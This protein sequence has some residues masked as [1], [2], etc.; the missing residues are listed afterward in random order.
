MKVRR[1]TLAA[2]LLA[3]AAGGGCLGAGARRAA[4]AG[5]AIDPKS[6]GAP[7]LV[8]LLS[9][10]SCV[11]LLN[12]RDLWIA[13]AREAPGGLRVEAFVEPVGSSAELAAFIDYLKLPF[14][15]SVLPTSAVP[16]Q[17]R[18]Q[19]RAKVLLDAEGNV[20]KAFPVALTP[21]ERRRLPAD[22]R[23]AV[24]TIASGSAGASR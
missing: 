6:A 16:E 9:P 10:R 13:L 4:G 3:L 7:R 8:I 20:V 18:S 12:E 19:G 23:E 21:D 17:I 14:P 22:I 1:P 11:S 24:A 2:W 5:S 15:V